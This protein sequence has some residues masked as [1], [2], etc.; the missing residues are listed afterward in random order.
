[1]EAYQL[2]EAEAYRKIQQYSMVKRRS[3]KDIAEAIIRS[4]SKK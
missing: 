2:S 3:I 4:A 1:M